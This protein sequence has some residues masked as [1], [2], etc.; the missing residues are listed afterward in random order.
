MMLDVNRC[1]KKDMKKGFLAM[2]MSVFMLGACA[3]QTSERSSGN[4]TSDSATVST[5]SDTVQLGILHS[6]SGTIAISE[7]S[8]RDAELMAIEEINAAG[9]VLGKQIEP[10]VED[11]GSDWP[12]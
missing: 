9:G 8:L 10:I 5:E 11:G 1:K 3:A 4:E 7:V 6:L 12:T 2:L